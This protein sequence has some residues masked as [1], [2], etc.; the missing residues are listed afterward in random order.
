MCVGVWVCVHV[1]WGVGWGVCGGVVRKKG[2]GVRE[3]KRMTRHEC[4]RRAVL[5]RLFSSRSHHTCTLQQ[6]TIGLCV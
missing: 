3:G 4:N 2:E 1:G 5:L 6:S